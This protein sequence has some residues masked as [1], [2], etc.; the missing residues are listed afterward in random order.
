MSWG[1]RLRA[2]R[3]DLT[4]LRT[5]RDFRLLFVAGTVF[6]L[7][8]M[9]TYVAIPFQVYR[10]TGSN[11]AVGAIGLVELVPL[12]VFALYGG[13]LADHVDR[14]RLLVATGVAQ[15][16]ATAV[17]AA[18]AFGAFGP[19]PHLWL[20]FVLAAVLASTSSMQRP[21]REALMPR[22][23]RHDEIPAAQALTSLGMEI[24][25]LV[26]P[27]LG[28]LL[29]AYVGLGWCF[30]VDVVGLGVATLMYLAMRSY[31]HREETTPPS[32]A[33]VVQGARYALAR[34]DLLGTYLVDIAAMLLAMPVVLFPALAETVFEAPELL[35]LLYSAETVGALVATAL[36]G[37]TGRVHH[38]GRA[39]VLA[40]AAYGVCIALA[41]LMPSFWLVAVFF[42]LAG[43]AD[44]VSGVFRGIVWSQTIP[45]GMRGRLAGIEM[46]SYSLGPLGG[47]V[48]AGVTADLWSVRGSITSGGIACV[49]GVGA[50]A[51]WLRDFWSYDA[52]TDEHAV[53]ER[54]VRAARDEG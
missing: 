43:A 25:V 37:W 5:S 45:E 42:A 12:V 9:V 1:E 51:L 16:V 52:R 46:L 33:G 3:I 36:S 15:A 49:A 24:G 11:L 48:R 8:A 17:L 41:G 27:A 30:V 50:T 13:A 53:A 22:T 39:I 20:V 31:P 7:G 14:K 47:Q 29:I 18:N 34:R 26:G 38:H 10:V 19:D 6:Y 40:A 23:V 21:S 44:M 32:L 54:A 4:P 2:L 28:G 35:G